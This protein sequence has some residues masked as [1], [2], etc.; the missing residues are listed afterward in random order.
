MVLRSTPR[1]AGVLRY[2][3]LWKCRYVLEVDQSFPLYCTD[4]NTVVIDDGNYPFSSFFL[5]SIL[6][7]KRS[8]L[9]GQCKPKHFECSPGE[10]IPSPWVCDGEEV[11]NGRFTHAY[12]QCVYSIKRQKQC[13]RY[14]FANA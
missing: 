4:A 10:C 6:D 12:I 9:T 11:G 13:Y 5:F 14:L 8:M 7:P 3:C 1:K 2:S